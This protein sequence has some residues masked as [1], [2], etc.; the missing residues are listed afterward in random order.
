MVGR[1]TQQRQAER[2]V[3]RALEAGVLDD[4]QSLIVIHREHCVVACEHLWHEYRVGRQRPV[5]ADA[6]GAQALDRRGDD[7]RLLLAEVTAFAGVRIQ[8]AD[9]DPR[10][11]HGEPPR[12]L[13]GEDRAHLVQRV[14]GER[15]AHR[16]ERQMGGCERH[17]QLACGQHHHG[18]CAVGALRE[19]LGMAA[20]RDA[21]VVDHALVH[22]RRDDGV[23][24]PGQCGLD[25]AVEECQYV[26]RVGRLEPPRHAR[27]RERLV[28]HAQ[29][30]AQRRR[31]RRALCALVGHQGD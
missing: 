5:G 2:H 31:R 4:R 29:R 23:E 3:D 9:R 26:R 20:E 11:A 19:V 27:H 22:R 18:A 13:T 8:P 24:L 17:A 16:G 21:G 1:G 25:G 10:V 28:R 30:A 12:E 14:D 15:A 6:G 7:A